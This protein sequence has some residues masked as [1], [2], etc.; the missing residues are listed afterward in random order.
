M[1]RNLG[2]TW[3]AASAANIRKL[4]PALMLICISIFMFLI[5]NSSTS[6]AKT[7]VVDQ[8]GD[9]DFLTIQEAVDAAGEGDLLYIQ[10]GSYKGRILVNKS[11]EI[12]GESTQGVQVGSGEDYSFQLQG[13]DVILRN[14]TLRNY[15][16][17]GVQLQGVNR[18]ELTELQVEEGEGEALLA[19]NSGNITITD[20][21]FG[22]AAVFNGTNHSELI[23]SE[24]RTLEFRDSLGLTAE[25]SSL[26][27]MI[28]HNIST[29]VGNSSFSR[30][31]AH[32]L[33][34]ASFYG[35]HLE[36]PRADPGEPDILLTNSRQ[37][38]FSDSWLGAVSLLRSG[39]NI[40]NWNNLSS[41]D[42]SESD[43]VD[44]FNNII[45]NTN[46]VLGSPLLYLNSV[47]NQH[48]YLKNRTFGQLIL[49]HCK[50]LVLEDALVLYEGA[51]IFNSEDILLRNLSFASNRETGLGIEN[52]SSI[53]VQGLLS[54]P[55]Y[56]HSLLEELGRGDLEE[57]ELHVLGQDYYSPRSI[58]VEGVTNFHLQDSH[59]LG[60]ESEGLSIRDSSTVL[61]SGNSFLKDS[62]STQVNSGTGISLENLLETKLT[63]ND[64]NYFKY[65]LV[66]SSCLELELKNNSFQGNQFAV[67]SY[68]S[69]AGVYRDNQI[70][71]SE[72]AYLFLRSFSRSESPAWR[73]GVQEQAYENLLVR[74]TIRNCQDG[75]RLREND[76]ELQ[77]VTFTGLNF[78]G[79]ALELQ[80]GSAARLVNIS[81]SRED[82]ILEDDSRVQV[83]NY[84]ALR[85]R[86][87]LTKDVSLAELELVDSEEE[88]SVFYSTPG[89]GGTNALS[90][91]QGR[92]PLIPIHSAEI[93]NF[94]T[95]SHSL[96]L[97]FFYS[98]FSLET[99]DMA[100]DSYQE[101]PIT[102][103]AASPLQ[104]QDI[105]DS[106]SL[107][108]DALD[109]LRIDLTHY[110]TDELDP[111]SSLDYT[112][113]SLDEENATKLELEI[114]ENGVLEMKVNHFTAK[115]W[116]GDI[117]NIVVAARDSDERVTLSR[118]FC[119]SVL[120]VNDPPVLIPGQEFPGTGLVV[121]EDMPFW[122]PF[123]IRDVDTP[124]EDLQI[125]S[126]TPRANYQVTNASLELLY[127][128]G[129]EPETVRLQVFD[130]EYTAT[131]AMEI[132]FRPQNDRPNFAFLLPTHEAV[133]R[134]L[135]SWADEDVDSS[136]LVDIYYDNN[137]FGEDGVLIIGGLE[138]DD[139]EDGYLWD[140]SALDPGYYYLYAVIDDGE[141][142]TL[143]YHLN[144]IRVSHTEYSFSLKDLVFRDAGGGGLVVEGQLQN[145][146][147][148][149]V[150]DPILR[151]YQEGELRDEMVLTGNLE[152]GEKTGF[153]LYLGEDKEGELKLVYKLPAGGEVELSGFPSHS[154]GATET[155]SEDAAGMP[156]FTLPGFLVVLVFFFLQGEFRRKRG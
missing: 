127:P 114:D 142:R 72:L 132:D 98:D 71:G 89:F 32:E 122:F 46:S 123:E 45:P 12:Q 80:E 110:F 9:G 2:K 38:L 10:N 86:N 16:L 143:V 97:K 69:S 93:T 154:S 34:D 3:K 99:Q 14:L 54:L 63:G 30:L 115:D 40:F 90:D 56:D 66:I 51:R 91:E 36:D 131:F 126:N 28:L 70:E 153:Q 146:G 156:G 49:A 81:L 60:N 33:R 17:A 152:P 139:E 22:G 29:T 138:E 141:N 47:K 155:E 108:E 92:F 150:V 82:M 102:I 96:D 129:S 42:F 77:S 147:E 24:F 100:I 68:D 1:I 48:I 101:M 65:G 94:G 106:F 57:T 105:P 44:D 21:V 134:F 87:R 120:P 39:Q 74:E 73:G 136:A 6:S 19:K 85:V 130:G 128:E 144:K 78:S 145:T 26:G 137:A 112:V 61:I 109:P 20:S 124:S 41:L 107:N 88:T 55:V 43:Q 13:D 23:S 58:L 95:I 52:S 149:R 35:L 18:C 7:H 104:I 76:L 151:L 11:L 135:I 25:N 84:L 140:V 37:N 27:D 83:F 64:I 53:H 5:V 79:H 133:D 121:Y 75:V 119:V 118:A 103:N 4:A 62:G 59:V 116:Y 125:I 31:R 117:Q 148:T 67:R 8:G 111:A 113:A 50:G 15:Q